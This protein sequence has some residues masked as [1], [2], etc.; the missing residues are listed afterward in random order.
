MKIID[1]GLLSA[2]RDAVD[3]D[4]MAALSEKSAEHL[5]VD[6]FR[7]YHAVSSVYSSIFF[8]TWCLKSLPWNYPII[9]TK[10]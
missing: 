3:F 8:L 1:V 6:Y 4:P 7:F 9:P 2:F 10:T 5:P